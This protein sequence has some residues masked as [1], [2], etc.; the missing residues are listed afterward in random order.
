MQSRIWPAS[1]GEKSTPAWGGRRWRCFRGIPRGPGFKPHSDTNHTNAPET[2]P[3]GRFGLGFKSVYLLTDLPEIHSGAWHFAI[4]A[5]CLPKEVPP[6]PDL[7]EDVTRVRLPLRADVQALRDASRLIDLVPFLRLTTRLEFQTQALAVFADVA[8]NE[9]CVN[10]SAIVERVVISAPGVTSDGQLQFL[11]CRSRLHAGQIALLFTN[12]GAPARWRDAFG[13]DLFAALP[14]KA[15]LGCGVAVSHRFE[16]QSG[17]THLVDPKTNER[18]IREAADLLTDLVAGLCA[19]KN[20]GLSESLRRF[21]AVWRWER[22]DVECEQ[23]CSPDTQ[24]VKGSAACGDFAY[25]SW[26]RASPVE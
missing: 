1:K 23:M 24:S 7:P 17:R 16:V 20:H 25:R 11:R 6:P 3:I 4:E 26:R 9:I 12:D 5:G 8:S 19:E 15:E 21:W 22:G 2:A 13:Y 14:L 10:D 18:L